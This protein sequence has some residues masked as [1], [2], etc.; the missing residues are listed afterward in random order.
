MVSGISVK[1]SGSLVMATLHEFLCQC[2]QTAHAAELIS[3][4]R[5]KDAE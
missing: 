1:D 5:S 3:G 2:G 4:P